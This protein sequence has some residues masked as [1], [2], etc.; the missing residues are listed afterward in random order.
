MGT[1]VWSDG[2]RDNC[3]RYLAGDTTAP[4]SEWVMSGTRQIQ[5][6]CNDWIMRQPLRV[7]A[8]C[9]LE[10]LLAITF[11]LNALA[12]MREW[13]AMRRRLRRTR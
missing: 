12:D 3:T 11:V 10:L 7:Q 5:V 8:L 9:L 13:L 6:S 4:A 1:R 2:Q